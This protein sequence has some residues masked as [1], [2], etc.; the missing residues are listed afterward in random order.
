MVLG[1]IRKEKKM[2]FTYPKPCMCCGK[3]APKK[4]EYFMT[5]DT[6]AI[7][8]YKGNLKVIAKHYDGEKL[9]L[10]DG[11]SYEHKNGYFCTLSCCE[12]YAN[13]IVDRTIKRNIKSFNKKTK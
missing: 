13:Y 2:I 8:E 11:E 9:I 4:T 10:W 5:W 3:K 7:D 1:Q 6:P 12:R